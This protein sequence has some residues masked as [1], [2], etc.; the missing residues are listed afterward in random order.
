MK[1]LKTSSLALPSSET[2]VAAFT[3]RSFRSEGW[4]TATTPPP[5]G[6]SRGRTMVRM[7]RVP[8][9]LVSGDEAVGDGDELGIELGGEHAGLDVA[10]Q[11][12]QGP[13]AAINDPRPDK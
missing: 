6:A 1:D 11:P 3:T 10:R 5:S 9:H 13:P 12:G 8:T 2:M 4:S 7:A